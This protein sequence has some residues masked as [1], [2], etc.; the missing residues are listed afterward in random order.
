[1]FVQGIIQIH[2]HH[3]NVRVLNPVTS[4]VVKIQFIE[5]VL[6]SL[7]IDVESLGRSQKVKNFVDSSVRDVE[8]TRYPD[9]YPPC[10]NC[11]K[12]DVLLDLLRYFH[13]LTVHF[14]KLLHIVTALQ[15]M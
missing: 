8:I 10:H 11:D 15:T 7:P 9:L 3:D 5:I 6:F 14:F 2:L 4:A 13:A 12:L 1:M